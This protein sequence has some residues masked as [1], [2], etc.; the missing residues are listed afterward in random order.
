MEDLTFEQLPAAVTQIQQQLHNIEMLLKAYNPP[1]ESD[2]VDITVA[3][4][5]TNLAIGTLYSKT[6]RN[7]IPH[8]KEG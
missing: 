5:F 6:S 1:K 7:E 8:F 4:E 3:V 2:I